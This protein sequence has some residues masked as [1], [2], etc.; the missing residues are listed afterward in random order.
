MFACW[1][2]CVY[3]EARE[4]GRMLVYP[5]VS[6]LALNFSTI[7]AMTSRVFHYSGEQA[8]HASSASFLYSVS[9]SFPPQANNRSLH[10]DTRPQYL[11]CP[12]SSVPSSTPPSPCRFQSENCSL[13]ISQEMTNIYPGTKYIPVLSSPSAVGLIMATGVIGDSLKGH[14]SIVMSRDAGVTWRQVRGEDGTGKW[15]GKGKVKVGDGKLR[16]RLCR[17]LASVSLLRVAPGMQCI[18]GRRHNF[19]S[20]DG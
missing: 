2:S 17:R 12:P 7:S 4:P 6:H 1:F 20:A 8:F 18:N 9:C 15:E 11:L 10:P 13:H 16:F 3:M 5:T 14:P 19:G